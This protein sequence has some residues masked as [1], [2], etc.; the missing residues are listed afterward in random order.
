MFS[1]K[2]LTIAAAT[3]RRAAVLSALGATSLVLLAAG[4]ASAT[5]KQTGT[6]RKGCTIYSIASGVTY[7]VPDGTTVTRTSAAGK[8]QSQTCDNGTWTFSV[9]TVSGRLTTVLTSTSAQ[10][11]S[12]AG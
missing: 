6:P 7:T 1:S 4:P 2:M 3:R 9:V 12:S 10:L 5:P 11:I 8:T